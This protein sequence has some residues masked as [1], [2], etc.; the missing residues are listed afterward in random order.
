MNIRG[1]ATA[2]RS[3]LLKGAGVAALV[4]AA[5][6]LTYHEADVWENPW[7]HA[8]PPLLDY[9]SGEATTGGGTRISIDLTLTRTPRPPWPAADYP[10]SA[11]RDVEGKARL[12]DSAGRQQ[13]YEVQGS[14]RDANGRHSL[15]VLQAASKEPPGIRFSSLNLEWDGGEELVASGWLQRVTQT[16][17]TLMS[18]SDPDLNR[19]TKLVLHRSAKDRAACG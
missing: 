14:I 17:S 10:E 7:A 16:G 8:R 1:P 19:P 6:V 18:T 4:V 12:C 5:G 13:A 15:L 3:N 2:T 11:Q 9:W